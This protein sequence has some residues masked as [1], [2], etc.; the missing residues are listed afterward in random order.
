MR[1]RSLILTVVV[2]ASVP[3]L[4]PV[5]MVNAQLA[6]RLTSSNWPMSH[7]SANHIGVNRVDTAIN[8]TN[9][10]RLTVV[11]KAQ[12]GDQIRSAPA[13]ANGTVFVGS[14]DHKV[15]AFDAATA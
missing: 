7:Y 8:A 4:R 9:V 10:D 12:T 2:L 14:D 6:Q 11:W 5:E 1:F 3:L 13:E 15:Y